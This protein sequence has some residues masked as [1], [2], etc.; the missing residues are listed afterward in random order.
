MTGIAMVDC[1]CDYCGAHMSKRKAD[2]DRGWGRFCDKSCKA[3]KAAEDKRK[4][5]IVTLHIPTPPISWTPR[6][7][8]TKPNKPVNSTRPVLQPAMVPVVHKIPGPTPK[9]KKKRESI[10]DTPKPENFGEWS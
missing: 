3:L 5:A 9:P 4:A 1:D 8:K 10:L 7:K 2:R 6:I